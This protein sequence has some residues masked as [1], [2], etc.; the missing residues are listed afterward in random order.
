[1]SGVFMSDFTKKTLAQFGWTEQDSVPESIGEFLLAAKDRAAT[2]TRTDVMV[3]IEKML[4]G[5]VETAKQMLAEQRAKDKQRK[6]EAA[7]DEKT[8]NMTP[9]VAEAYRKMLEATAPPPPAPEEAKPEIVDDRG[10]DQ[11]QREPEMASPVQEDPP[12][13]AVNNTPPLPPIVLPFCPRCG[14]DMRMKYDVEIT[15]QDKEAFVAILLGNARFKKRYSFLGDKFV[16][17][18]RS[19]L[20]DENLEIHRQLVV[21]NQAGELPGENEWFLRMFEY[22][23]A[24]SIESVYDGA[25]KPLAIVP[26]LDEMTHKPPPDNPLETGLVYLRKYVNTKVLAHEVTRR[27]VGQQFRRFQRLIEA[28][29]AMA[30]EPSFWDGIG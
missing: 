19:L 21:D 7:I 14:W 15:D 26:P 13:Q 17:T 3:D 9:S 12:V 28:L 10:A 11:A 23:L 20:A 27:L 29:E 6:A 4:P 18:L 16:V 8:K 30:V 24:C 5:D 2:T 22:R 25:G 1:M